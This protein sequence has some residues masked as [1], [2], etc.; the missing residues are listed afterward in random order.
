MRKLLILLL[1]IFFLSSQITARADGV[2][3]G[4]PLPFPFLFYNFNQ[5][6]YAQPAYYGGYYRQPYYAPGYYRHAYYYGGYYRPS[7]WRYRPGWYG[8]RWPGYYRP[9]WYG[10]WP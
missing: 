1:P 8:Y 9:G 10:Y 5:N 3:F 7:Y 6:Y 4:I 2:S